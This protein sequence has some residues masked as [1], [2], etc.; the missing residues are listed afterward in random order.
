M[1]N[2]C[3][4][5]ARL[6]NEDTSKIDALEA[7]LKKENDSQPLNHLCPN[8]DGKWDYAWSCDNWGT[9]WDITPMDWERESDNTIVMHFDSAWSPPTTLYE[10]L[11][12]E[13]WTVSAMYHEPG[14]GFIGRFEDGFDQYFE[15]DCTDRESVENLPEDLIDYGNL[16]E[17]VE[18]FEEEAFEEKMDELERTEWYIGQEPA[19]VGRYE[20]QTTAWPY[21]QWCNWDGTKWSRWEGDDIKVTQWRGLAEEYKE[22]V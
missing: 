22:S 5:T 15:Y 21:P 18:R 11:E 19:Y 7:E 17:E 6:T 1:P 20:V 4:N 9:K 2:W 13:G 16:M 14:M 10:F 12:Q 8:P 3:Y